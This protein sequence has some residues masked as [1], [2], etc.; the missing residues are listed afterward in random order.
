M[1][2]PTRP[3]RPPNVAH[4]WI[5]IGRLRAT[6]DTEV[7]RVATGELRTRWCGCQLDTTPIDAP[8]SLTR[9]ERR[10]STVS[11]SRFNRASAACVSGSTRMLL[12]LPMCDRIRAWIH[13]V[14]AG[15]ID[16]LDRGLRFEILER[17]RQT[18]RTSSAIASPIRGFSDSFVTRSTST[19]SRSVSSVS[20][21]TSSNSETGSVNVTRTSRSLSESCSPRA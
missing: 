9:R 8:R 14:P 6:A 19:P 17:R 4:G 18:Y 11:S 16:R 3:R 13:G 12:L 10:S 2:P 5:S 1:C 7:C 20:S 21:R 15:R